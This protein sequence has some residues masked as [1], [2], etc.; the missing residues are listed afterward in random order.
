MTSQHKELTEFQH[1][2]IMVLG[3]LPIVSLFHTV[4]SSSLL[5]TLCGT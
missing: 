1:S 2:E 3:N 5:S 4:T